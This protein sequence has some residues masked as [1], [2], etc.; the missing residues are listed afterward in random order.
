MNEVID[1]VNK[2]NEELEEKYNSDFRFLLE[3]DGYEYII[4]FAGFK[5]Y[6]SYGDAREFNEKLN[7]YEPLEQHIRDLYN[8]FCKQL[9]LNTL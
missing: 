8:G 3:T 1:I 9:Y 4:K 5:L 7:E 6:V 2:L